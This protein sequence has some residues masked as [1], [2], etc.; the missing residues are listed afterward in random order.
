MHMRA[1]ASLAALMLTACVTAPRVKQDVGFVRG[2]WFQRSAA[3]NAMTLSLRFTESASDISVLNGQLQYYDGENLDH[4]VEMRLARDG[5]MMTVDP[6]PDNNPD[7]HAGVLHRV[8]KPAWLSEFER[9]GR[10]QASSA[11]TAYFA[12]SGQE[13]VRVVLFQGGRD[14]LK[15]TYVVRPSPDTVTIKDEFSGM[16]D[17][18]D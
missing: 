17:D 13:N 10:V 15:L 14:E 5:S 1:G 16:R 6:V 3:V 7:S 8:P 4:A 11:P 2:C 9:S 12:E 18:C